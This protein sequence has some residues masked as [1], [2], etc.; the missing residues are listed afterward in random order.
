MS[1]VRTLIHISIYSDHAGVSDGYVDLGS[2]NSVDPTWRR[3][4]VFGGT[5]ILQHTDKNE[6]DSYCDG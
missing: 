6:G 2:D 1:Y 5:N 4:M 3:H